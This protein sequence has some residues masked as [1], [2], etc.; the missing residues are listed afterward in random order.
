MI[1]GRADAAAFLTRLLR[2]DPAALVRLR[3]VSAG[4]LAAGQVSAGQ[5]SAERV[6]LWAML[7]FKVLVVRT[8]A[9]KAPVDVTVAA[10]ELLAA[11]TDP[12]APHPVAR[13]AQW[14]HPLPPARGRVLEVLP[15]ADVIRVAAAAEATLRAAAAQGVGGRAVGERV[16]REALLDHVPIVVTGPDGERFDVPQRLVQGLVRMGFVARRGQGSP[17]EDITNGDDSVTIRL[18]ARWLGLAAPFGSAWYRPS[19]GLRVH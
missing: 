5:V 8:V 16:L 13:D 17:S 10:A 6:E 19:S 7:P 14:H 3:P 9:A 4:E 12:A 1:E 15:M 11:T 18:A 2:L